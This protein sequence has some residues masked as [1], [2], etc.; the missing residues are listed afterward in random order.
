MFRAIEQIQPN[1]VTHQD[2]RVAIEQLQYAT[3]VRQ[4]LLQHV[5]TQINER[6]QAPR[7]R[8]LGEASRW[9]EAFSRTLQ[10]G[11]GVIQGS[12]ALLKQ[13]AQATE[14]HLHQVGRDIESIEAAAEAKFGMV[15]RLR[16]V[17][18]LEE[19][20]T[21][22]HNHLAE[23]AENM[24]KV[25]FAMFAQDRSPGLVSTIARRTFATSPRLGM[26]LFGLAG[27]GATAAYGSTAPALGE[28]K[29]P[30]IPEAVRSTL[31]PTTSARPA[32]TTGEMGVRAARPVP[33]AAHSLVSTLQARTQAEQVAQASQKVANFFDNL[34]HTK[35]RQTFV[36]QS[37]SELQSLVN[38]LT[39]YGYK[40]QDILWLLNLD[41]VDAFS[42]PVTLDLRGG[43]R[44]PIL[45]PYN[46]AAQQTGVLPLVAQVTGAYHANAETAPI[47]AL[48]A[49][50]S[51]ANLPSAL[52]PSDTFIVYRIQAD[53]GLSDIATRYGTTVAQ[54]Q[55]DN[56][57]M[58]EQVASG[59]NLLIRRPGA[60]LGSEVPAPVLSSYDSPDLRSDGSFGVIGQHVVAEE[61]VA[62]NSSQGQSILATY[63]DTLFAD[64]EAMPPE[65]K[66]YLVGT[67]QE[68]ATFFNVRPGDLMGILRLEQNNAGWRLQETRISSAG[69]A[70]VAQIVPRTWNG[71]ANPQR[72]NFVQNVLDIE[73]HGGLG[74]DWAFRNEWQAWKEGRADRSVLLAS[75]ADPQVF[76][77][78]VAGVARHLV[79]WGLTQDFA[80][81]DPEGFADRLADAIA[82][83]NSGR[84][85]D[86]SADW[87]QSSANQKTTAQ[88]VAE[89]MAISEQ[90][91]A[92]VAQ[93]SVAVP[94]AE[95]V[96][97]FTNRFS[98]LYDQTFGTALS[99]S[100]T[101]E[102]LALAPALVEEVRLGR[103]DPQAAAIEL[104]GM[105][106]QYYMA[107]GYAALRDGSERLW[108][109]IHNPATLYA[110][111]T[112]TSLLGHPLTLYEMDDLMNRTKGDRDA[113]RA[114]LMGRDESRL[115][116]QARHIAD[117]MLQRTQRGMSVRNS[118]V[119][120]WIQPILAGYSPLHMGDDTLQTLIEQFQSAVTALPEY[121]QL[122]ASAQFRASPLLPM[123][124]IFKEFGVAVDYQVGGHHTGIDVANPRL[125]DGSEPPIFAV[126]DATVAHVG[127]LYCEAPNACRGGQAIVL[128]HGDNVYSLYSHNSI[129]EVKTG[130]R[131]EAGQ[132]IGRQGNEGY[133]FGS[134]LH[135]EVHVGAPF[136]GDWQKP[137][138]GGE[139]ADPA[140]WLP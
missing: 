33:A 11:V 127:P 69:A 50:Q 15:K 121:S 139:F 90:F 65:A 8:D 124:E 54:I 26:I 99:D 6:Y 25:T 38:R 111:R 83:Y 131:V 17:T 61:G 74:F 126:D 59:Q 108:P 67:V 75:N 84:T 48:V 53:E 21:T 130:D 113:I 92:I 64:I 77:N 122:H 27:M 117:Q 41:S 73:E 32:L 3:D 39:T 115:F 49:G 10:L 89:A 87:T 40:E 134:H 55:A 7:F 31:S 110:Q 82:V 47:S 138:A 19:A 1:P 70:G 42:Q 102:L 107:T 30:S 114:E 116:V 133:S 34:P 91:S 36:I 96:E 13:E 51:T 57:L 37:R 62:Y 103:Q 35:G 98:E 24:E 52:R 66:G 106:E 112:A 105:A 18:R 76:E 63:G 101:Q 2:P 140:E 88:Y 128:D 9:T 97:L 86:Q 95:A 100:S 118:E 104:L 58:T 16:W 123:P 132:R 135:F 80:E 60:P 81:R 72:S 85:L 29:L 28:L 68:V 93:P 46:A 12:R 20:E 71:W 44:M 136:S 56:Q 120:T 94:S 129:A 23:R 78:S 45:F 5:L 14:Q 119:T 4:A 137:F 22:I 125:S 109:F 79:H 43:S